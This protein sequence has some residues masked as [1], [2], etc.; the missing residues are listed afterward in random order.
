[1]NKNG[2]I[3]ETTDKLLHELFPALYIATDQNKIDE[4][5]TECR[6]K[7][8]RLTELKFE[9]VESLKSY[10]TELNLLKLKNKY[11]LSRV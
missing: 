8:D 7:I 4:I 9:D 10:F 3:I 5:K 11:N 6:Q 2:E 1:M